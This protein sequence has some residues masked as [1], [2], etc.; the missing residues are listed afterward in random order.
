MRKIIPLLFFAVILI[1]NKT[2]SQTCFGNFAGADISLPCGT[3]CTPFTAQIPE[4]RSTETYS[5]NPIP[6][7]PYPY[8]TS[9]PYMTHPCASNQDDKFF[10]TSNFS[11]NFCFY[12]TTYTSGSISTNGAISFNPADALQG[13]NYVINSPIPFGGTGAQ[14]TGTCPFPIGTNYPRP[15]IFG[16]YHDILPDDN[17]SGIPKVESR[18]EGVSPC[19]R[20]ISSFNKIPIFGCQS[21]SV[22]FEIVL[23]ESTN[24]IEVYVE[25]KPFCVATNSSPIIGLQNG[26]LGSWIAAP[27]RNFFSN[28]IS[29]EAW[30]FKPTG[31]TSLLDHVELV[32]NGTVVATG[33][34]GTLNNGFYDVDFGTVCPPNQ[35]NQ[36][37]VRGV[38]KTC[39]NDPTFFNIDDTVNIDRIIPF[40]ANGSIT[41]SILC[42]GDAT[43]E[44][45]FN[46]IGNT[47]PYE[48]SKNA[49]VTYQT[50]NVFS[51]LLA[52]PN[53]FRIKDVNGCTKD[54]TINIPEPTVLTLTAIQTT[55]T[56]CSNKTGEITLTA[57][58]GRNPYE[59]SIDGGATYQASNIFS[60][61]AVGTYSQLQIKDFNNCV[62][63]H[64]P[65]NITLLDTMRLNLGPD[66]TI[67]FGQTVLMLTQTNAETDTFR[68]TPTRP[69][70]DFDTA[71]TPI[72][73]PIDTTTYR[74]TAKWG[75]CSRTDDIV[76][77]VKHKP[78]PEAGKDTTICFNTFAYLKGS[79]SNLSGSV[80]YNWAP[81]SMV[82]PA[83]AANAIARPDTT[84]YFYLTV[85]DNYGCNFSVVD[86]VKITMRDPVPAFAGNDTI[87]MYKKP[88][89]LEA[90]GGVSYVW[91]PAAPLNNPFS[92]TPL[93]LL[94]HDQYFEVLV[95]DEIGCS[96]VDGIF[97]K[98][99]EGPTYH[100][101]NAFTPNG[102]GLNEIFRPIPS[103]I[104]S[105]EYFRIFDRYGNLIFQTREWMKGWNGN[106]Q[107]KPAPTGT[108]VWS[109]KGIDVNGSPVDMK[110]TVIL[111]R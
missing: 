52:G 16:L 97:V 77:N 86:S 18:I 91:T 108:Y 28:P 53:T 41:K 106:L 49:G 51:N 99:Y 92:R 17:P 104:Q 85:T 64:P 23:Y 95:K 72:C 45:T 7:N 54:T 68:W 31:A 94:D 36:Y 87:G 96:A 44:V 90:T 75:I 73:S 35:N 32:L 66:S 93:A 58:G 1:T 48:Y 110:G 2:Y 10:N 42:N 19:R 13:S 56:N 79:A 20:F 4:I 111:I 34:I 78:V 76:I 25:N 101:P 63:T 74:V 15:S 14:G 107:G 55:Q 9:A 57:G 109:I 22:T 62:R 39:N 100:L 82:T 89:Q 24:I 67:C 46:P 71:R 80:N 60:G 50:S 88:H 5:V 84:R 29:N 105:T 3:N 40:Y 83:N 37:I 8:V 11:F 65:V 59:Y 30:Q 102:D 27:G 43:G 103:G 61:L 81:A 6:Y 21:D 26:N 33:T 69:L 98:V 70:L 47:N 12:G 38:Y